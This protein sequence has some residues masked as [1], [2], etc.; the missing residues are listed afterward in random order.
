MAKVCVFTPTYNRADLLQALFQSLCEQTVNDFE[1][2][3]VDDGSTDGTAEIV[4]E[5]RRQARFAIRYIYKE[6]GGK[7]RAVNLALSIC[8]CPIFFCVD[9]DDHLISDAIESILRLWPE[10]ESRDDLAGL[11]SLRGTT[12][13]TPLGSW[14]PSGVDEANSWDLYYELGFTGDASL[15]Y[16]TD[17]AKDYPYPVVDGERF[18]SECISSNEI[19]KR[20][21]MKLLNRIL[22]VG[23]YQ[24]GGLTDQSFRLIVENPQGYC[25]VKRQ[26]VEMSAHFLQKCYHTCLYLAAA[27]IA[28]KKSYVRTAPSTLIAAICLIPSFFAQYLLERSIR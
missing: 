11:I 2:L 21:S 18:I 16:K 5:F 24:K 14:M 10:I 8:E 12:V 9:S 17:V 1:W 26:S 22:V 7:Q 13:D 4:T 6:N 15:I 25:L 3:I 23:E 19:A 27:R 20:Y 28:K